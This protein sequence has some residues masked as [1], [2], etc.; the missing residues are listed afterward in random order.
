MAQQ[1]LTRYGIVTRE[2]ASAEALGGGFSS[3]YAIFRSLEERGRIRR[4]YFASGVGAAQFAMPA[5]LDLLRSLRQAPESPEVVRLSATDP[6]NP[7]GALL[8]W[9]SAGD[10]GERTGRGPTRSAGAQVVLVNGRLG[11]WLAR[12]RQMLLVF[13]PEA[14]PERGMLARA[15]AGALAEIAL[16]GE[17][18][19]GGLLI[20]DVNGL[21]A[22]AHPIAP[23]LVDAGF[24][25]SALGYQKRRDSDRSAR[26]PVTA[27]RSRRLAVRATTGAP[28]LAEAAPD[29]PDDDDE[30]EEDEDW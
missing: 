30:A 23:Y 8:K 10:E 14:E 22:A 28:A 17:G 19:H 15:V 26:G 18:R 24:V 5:A 12:G 2:V 4:G 9:P 7:Y 13:R 21:P 3:V 11:A 6:A 27:F 29:G 25:Q 20:T 16:T 1:L